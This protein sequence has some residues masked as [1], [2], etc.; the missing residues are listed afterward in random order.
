MDLVA[1]EKEKLR[2]QRLAFEDGERK[3]LQKI[4][5]DDADRERRLK[6]MNEKYK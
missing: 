6:L 1:I 2:K 4:K 5:D 3:R